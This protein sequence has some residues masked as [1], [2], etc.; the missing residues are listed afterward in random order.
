MNKLFR[1]DFLRQVNASDQNRFRAIRRLSRRDLHVDYGLERH[2]LIKQ[3]HSETVSAI[4]NDFCY[5]AFLTGVHYRFRSTLQ[6]NFK[7]GML[8][9][10]LIPTTQKRASSHFPNFLHDNPSLSH[11]YQKWISGNYLSGIYIDCLYL[12]QLITGKVEHDLFRSSP[13]HVPD[14]FTIETIDAFRRLNAVHG[15]IRIQD[16]FA[17]LIWVDIHRFTEITLNQIRA[18]VDFQ[19][20]S[21]ARKALSRITASAVVIEFLGHFSI[22]PLKHFQINFTACKSLRT[23]HEAWNDNIKQFENSSLPM[24]NL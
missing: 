2:G 22:H 12:Y 9:S 23:I 4:V 10:N 20:N 5:R 17:A 6:R 15:S 8:I 24:W 7:T 16:V 19:S 14:N 13:F 3:P 1:T 18:D 21:L 11:F